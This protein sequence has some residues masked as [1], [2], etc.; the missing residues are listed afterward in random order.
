MFVYNFILILIP[1]PIQKFTIYDSRFTDSNSIKDK[2]C[3]QWDSNPRSEELAPKASALDHSATLT[4]KPK[5]VG[6]A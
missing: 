3:Q 1:I 6:I 5:D 4:V 2:K